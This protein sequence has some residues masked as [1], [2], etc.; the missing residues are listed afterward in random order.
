[1]QSRCIDVASSS[2][3]KGMK[4]FS[5]YQTPCI[6]KNHIAFLSYKQSIQLRLQNR[7]E[8]H[9]LV[10]KSIVTLDTIVVRSISVE[11]LEIFS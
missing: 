7:Y 4:N 9:T 10:V 11:A 6:L 1:M 5:H 2:D 3:S 8:S